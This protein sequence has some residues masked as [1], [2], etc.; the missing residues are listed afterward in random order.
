VLNKATGALVRSIEL[1]VAPT[2]TPMTYMANGR[3][4]VVLAYGSGSS[5]GLIA[6]ALG[7]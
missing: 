4:F 1:T 3:Q 2:G 6:F 5:S 7:K